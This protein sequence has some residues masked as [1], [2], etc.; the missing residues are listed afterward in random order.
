[1][2]TTVQRKFRIQWYHAY[3]FLATFDVLVVLCG[4]Y[5]NHRLVN[6][7]RSSVSTSQAWD[8]R[9]NDFLQL[10]TLAA[11]A[12]SP[13]NDVFDSN[14]FVGESRR[15]AAAV[16]E[17]N[18]HAKR[19]RIDVRSTK[20]S[21]AE[22]EILDAGL[23]RSV[24]AMETMQAEG[25]QIFACIE[26]GDRELAGKRMAVADRANLVLARQ[27]TE[28]RQHVLKIKNAHLVQQ[29]ALAEQLRSIEFGLACGVGL[30]IVT[31][32]T[33]GVKTKRRHDR[34]TNERE[35]YIS[36][37]HSAQAELRVAQSH[38]EEK[39][40]ER[41]RAIAHT[42]ALL[43]DEIVERQRTESLLRENTLKLERSNREL[44]EFAHVASHDLQEP[45]RKV[46]AFGDRLM[47]RFGG[48]LEPDARTY[49]ERMQNA[50]QRMQTLINDL[51]TFSRVSSKKQP[52][53]P[54]D[55]GQVAHEVLDDLEVC[56][57]TKGAIVEV[58]ELPTVEADPTQMRQ[59]LQNLIGNALKFQPNDSQ[60][61]V[62]IRC[63]N[64]NTLDRDMIGEP[65]GFADDRP[66]VDIEDHAP[67][68]SDL[69]E[70]SVSDNGIGFDERYV[71]KIFT[72]F[73]RLHGRN[74]YEG[75]GV[76]LAVCRKIV[77]RHGGRIVAKSTPGHGATFVVTLPSFQSDTGEVTSCE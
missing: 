60:P 63:R 13:C 37:L 36:Q 54:V 71:D 75:S 10:G 26:S 73:Q 70:I 23:A 20:L 21:E 65:M 14:D 5:A 12:N 16:D 33:F 56:I 18:Q 42:N 7:F 32:I 45:L 55:L 47:T 72:V 35:Q 6:L 24:A 51:L 31:A 2:E 15:L 68:T 76:G 40:E 58:D 57:Q 69:Y 1:M 74:E 61:K 59:L 64:V 22:R 77:E 19:L 48:S 34:I 9:L 62:Q 38:L 4:Y 17:F 67:P 66:A 3:Y 25:K 39:I 8:A 44:Q 53:K 49:I 52:F 46:Q 41:T 43:R 30:M 11:N 50:T 27:L 29:Q 28:L